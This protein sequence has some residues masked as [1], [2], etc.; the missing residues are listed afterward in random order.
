[1]VDPDAE[2]LFVK[3]LM[4]CYEIIGSQRLQLKQMQEQLQEL[5][6]KGKKDTKSDVGKSKLPS[7]NNR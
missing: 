2:Y 4:R 1:M 3:Q 6:S 5:L 7:S